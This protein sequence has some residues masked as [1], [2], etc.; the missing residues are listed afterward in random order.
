MGQDVGESCMQTGT[1]NNCRSGD[2][3]PAQNSNGAYTGWNN[4]YCT[5]NC[6]LPPG[7]NRSTW[8]PGTRLPRGNCPEG[9]ICF[10][11]GDV[12]IAERD[13]GTCYRECRS[14][15]DCRVSEGYTCRRTFTRGNNR[16]YTWENGICVPTPCD[17]AP[18]AVN[19]CPSGMYCEAR[20][21]MQGSER[22][23]VG[24]CR[25]GS[26]PEPTVEPGPEPAPEAGVATD[27]NAET[28]SDV[29]PDVSSDDASMDPSSHDASMDAMG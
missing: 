29:S 3:V 11:D 8:W 27:A 19:T 17:P 10:P 2:C 18:S 26:R 9:S 5:A 6:T 7:W 15:A 25:P 24:V 14:D 1:T 21:R 20:V 23:I 28:G 13:P 16:P 4:G 22:I 12:G